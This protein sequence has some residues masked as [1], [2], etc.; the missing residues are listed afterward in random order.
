MEGMTQA[1]GCWEDI[2]RTQYNIQ[3]DI[4]RTQNGPRRVEGV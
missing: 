3:K 2:I 1:E 4:I